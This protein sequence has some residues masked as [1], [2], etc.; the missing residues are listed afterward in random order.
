MAH[1]KQLCFYVIANAIIV[2]FISQFYAHSYAQSATPGDIDTVDESL[3][4]IQELTKS[5]K[6]KSAIPYA[7]AIVCLQEKTL[8][9]QHPKF[10]LSLYRLGMLYFA[11][12]NKISAQSNLRK[13]LSILELSG[14]EYEDQKIKIYIGLSAVALSDKKFEYA[15]K[16][17]MTAI[18][19]TSSTEGAKSLLM[20]ECLTDLG[21]LH[22]HQNKYDLAK[23]NLQESLSIMEKATSA[24]KLNLA[25]TF[26]A[27]GKVFV[28][29]SEYDQAREFYNSALAKY[30]ELYSEGS[31]II[32][33]TIKSIEEVNNLEMKLKH[34]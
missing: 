22:C 33:S 16:M 24:N 19:I 23:M 34:E 8:G 12:G 21:I 27:L 25:N 10:A 11:A 15:E 26:Q 14:K 32:L 17:L 13:A 29:L 9:D 31:P 7:I 30:R 3:A 20:A 6:Y 1:K 2:L 28:A 4:R 18:E 5:G